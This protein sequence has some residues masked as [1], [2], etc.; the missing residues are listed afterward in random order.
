M[1]IIPIASHTDSRLGAYRNLRRRHPSG[2]RE[3][4]SDIVVEGAILV[5]RL[6]SSSFEVLSVAID[7]RRD[8]RPIQGL[9]ESI[10]VYELESREISQLL[11][12]DFHRGLLAVARRKPFRSIDELTPKSFELSLPRVALAAF[13]INDMEN[14]GSMMRSAAALGI[15]QIVLGPGTVDPYSRRAMRVSMGAAMSHTFYQMDDPD[16][17]LPMLAEKGFRTIAST[18][19][20]DSVGIHRMQHDERPCLLIMGNE[21]NGLP[22]QWQDLASDRVCVPMRQSI[23]SLNVAVASAILMHRL[24]GD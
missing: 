4:E 3:N 23:D 5:E 1:Q 20:E 10:P 18:L 11:G 2:G 7:S 24:V 15:N 22:P 17:E 9:A 14:M 16:A 12:F 8:T 6:I 13:Q 21:A 19:A